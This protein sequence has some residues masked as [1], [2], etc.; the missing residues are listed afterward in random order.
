MALGSEFCHHML[1]VSGAAGA[2]SRGVVHELM[3]RM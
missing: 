2:W 1:W 3:Q